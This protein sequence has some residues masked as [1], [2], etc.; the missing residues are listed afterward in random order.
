MIAILIATILPFSV[1]YPTTLSIIL[2]YS[3]YD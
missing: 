2:I 3:P 1:Y